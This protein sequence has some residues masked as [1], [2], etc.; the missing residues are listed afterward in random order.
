[1]NKL[2]KY[3]ISY[4]YTLII[5]LIS[6]IFLTI[7]NYFNIINPNVNKILMPLI[8]ILSLFIGSYNLGKKTNKKGYLEGLKYAI[9]FIIFTVIITLITKEKLNLSNI[10]IYIIYTISS[11]SGATLGIN[12]KTTQEE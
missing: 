5:I 9:I 8:I 11:I 1:M 6:N 3:L 4:L 12:K 7:F 10:L 2:N